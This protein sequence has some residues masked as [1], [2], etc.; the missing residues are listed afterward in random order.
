MG[1]FKNF[2]ISPEERLIYE[3][4]QCCNQTP[5][6]I[7]NRLNI[8]LLKAEDKTVYEVSRRCGIS[9]TKVY[10][11]LSRY[12]PNNRKWF[13]DQSRRPKNSPAKTPDEVEELIVNLHFN[14]KESGYYSGAGS[15]K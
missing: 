6:S 4:L 10:K 9:R 3:S 14:L 7:K 13:L 1:N 15:I 11:C 2:S 8:I 5:I 12:R